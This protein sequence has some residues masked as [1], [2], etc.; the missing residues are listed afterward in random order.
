MFKKQR[1]YTKDM[2]KERAIAVAK[3]APFTRLNLY[4]GIIP[5]SKC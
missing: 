2:A 5:S 1:L 3:I 4:T